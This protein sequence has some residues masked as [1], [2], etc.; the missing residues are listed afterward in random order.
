MDHSRTQVIATLCEVLKELKLARKIRRRTR[1]GIRSPVDAQAMKCAS[2]A[3]YAF[4]HVSKH[5]V[6]HRQT[7]LLRVDILEPGLDSAFL[8]GARKDCETGYRAGRH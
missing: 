6:I 2:H 3:G 1:D 8:G 4:E 5:G 7:L